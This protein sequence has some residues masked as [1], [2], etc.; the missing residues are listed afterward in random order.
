VGWCREREGREKS[1]VICQEMVEESTDIE[2]TKKQ[3]F[4][5][6]VH[7]TQFGSPFVFDEWMDFRRMVQKVKV[8]VKVKF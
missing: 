5:S 7:T 3:T 8:K 6:V 4:L 2:K 1:I